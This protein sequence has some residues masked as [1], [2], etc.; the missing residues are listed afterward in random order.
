MKMSQVFGIAAAALVGAMVVM[1]NSVS[2]PTV[3]TPTRNVVFYD[4]FE[5]NNLDSADSAGNAYAKIYTPRAYGWMSITANAAH[6]GKY[7][8]TADSNNTGLR[9]WLDNPIS[10]S[11]AG[12]EF[13]LMAKASGKTDLFAAL[14]TMGTSAGMLNNGFSAL[15]GMG[16]D[17]SDSLWYTFQKYDDPQ[18]DSDLIKKNFAALQ[19]NTW[20]KC[21]VEYDFAAQRLTYYLNGSTVFTRSAPGIK[22]LDMFVTYRDSLGAQGPK[23][24]YIDDLTVYKR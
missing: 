10:D 16:I 14:V 15:L 2:G 12:L 24:Y 21:A 18:A 4:G 8:L 17:K 6:A 3:T 1:C 19:F 7:S 20:Y 13:Y 22:K 11:I 9:R 5:G 23:D